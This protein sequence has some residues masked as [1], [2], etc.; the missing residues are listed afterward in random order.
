MNDIAKEA[1]RLIE[2]FKFESGYGICEDTG[3]KGITEEQSKQCVLICLN[4]KMSSLKMAIETFE[5]EA[6][7]ELQ[8][9][10]KQYIEQNY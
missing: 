5:I 6:E 10:I 2:L 7:I 3:I 8:E 1:E 4:E 9:Q